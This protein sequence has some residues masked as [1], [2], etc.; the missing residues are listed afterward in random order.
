M[1][2]TPAKADYAIKADKADKADITDKTDKADDVEELFAP[3]Q[4]PTVVQPYLL[5]PGDETLS[6]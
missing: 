1:S 3:S 6:S 4:L 2:L 5:G